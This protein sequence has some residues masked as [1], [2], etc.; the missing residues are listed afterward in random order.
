MFTGWVELFRCK[1]GNKREFVSLDAHKY[2]VGNHNFELSKVTPNIAKFP[3]SAVTSPI[4]P[5]DDKEDLDLYRRSATE[6]PDHFSKE[7]TR[8]YTTPNLSFSAPRAPSQAVTRVEWDPRA[9]HARGG[10]GFHP[11]ASQDDDYHM[12]NKI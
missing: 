1:F 7:A 2:T 6:T 9:T 11:P 10:L 8:D 5:K 3:E 12:E 4:S